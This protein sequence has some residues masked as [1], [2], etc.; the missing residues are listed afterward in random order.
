MSVAAASGEGSLCFHEP[1]AWLD[2][3]DDVF[4]AVWH[5]RKHHR[6][7]GIADHGLGFHLPEIMRRADPRTLIIQRPVDEVNSSL[8][9][10]GLPATNFCDLLRQALA[11]DHPRI[12]RVPYAALADSWVVL[13]CLRW[14]MPEEVINRSQIARL[15]ARN[16]QAG[17]NAIPQA[18]ARSAEMANF[19]PADVLKRLRV[20]P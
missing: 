7:V 15:Q 16:I 14:L 17:P 9:R 13:D 1:T 3:W 11:Y 5:D 18:M 6:Y 10:L 4:N 20:S 12:M 8:A 2:R 19:I